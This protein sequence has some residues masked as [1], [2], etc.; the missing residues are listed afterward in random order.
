MEQVYPSGFLEKLVLF[1]G[2][3]CVKNAVFMTVPE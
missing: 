3:F 2:R 1:P